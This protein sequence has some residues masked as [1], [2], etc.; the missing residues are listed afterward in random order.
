MHDVFTRFSQDIGRD[1]LTNLTRL[2]AFRPQSSLSTFDVEWRP[3]RRPTQADGIL[4]WHR[5]ALWNAEHM[6]RLVQRA[7]WTRA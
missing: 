6:P 5:V 2:F 3:E 4:S 7:P 1:P